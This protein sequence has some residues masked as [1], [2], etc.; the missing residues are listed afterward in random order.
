MK[1]A[2]LPDGKTVAASDNAP[3]EAVCPYC[4]GVLLLR[5]RR[6]MKQSVVAFY[7]RHAN[8]QNM[9]CTARKRPFG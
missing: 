9:K 3:N 8:N 7:W 1:V 5:R 6:T 4:R 2:L